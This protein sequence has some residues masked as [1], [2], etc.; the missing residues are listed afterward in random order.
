MNRNDPQ[1]QFNGRLVLLGFGS[2]GQAVLPLL[3]RHLGLTPD[4]VTIVKAGEHKVDEAKR[5]GV[6]VIVQALT[7]DNYRSVLDPCCRPATSC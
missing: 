1:V 7:K 4:R 2:V 3:F 5:H 6:H